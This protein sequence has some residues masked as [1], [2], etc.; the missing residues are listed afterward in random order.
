MNLS[1]SIVTALK[2]KIV[3]YKNNRNELALLAILLLGLFLRIYD[4]S[5]ESIWFDEG[6][7]VMYAEL[8]I[9]Q[10]L[11]T[12]ASKDCTPPLYY[13]ILHYWVGMFGESEFF[14]KL[15][16]VIIGLSS[17]YILYKV[18]TL[19]FNK[20]V[21]LLS[22]LI[23]AI[24]SFHIYY[25]Q[26][27]RSYGLMVLLTLLSFYFLIKILKKRKLAVSI[28]YIITSILLMYTHVYGLFIIIAQNIFLLTLFLFSHKTLEL[29]FRKWILIQCV[30]VIAYA[31]WIFFGLLKQI[32]FVQN[33]HWHAA[34]KV[35]HIINSFYTY[36]GSRSLLMVFLALSFFS[37]LS[38][39]RTEDGSFDRK[40][41]LS[42][43]ED[44]KL[45]LG[46]SNANKIYFLLVWL[47]TPIILPF[48]ISIFITP[49]YV[50]RFTITASLAF[51]LLVAKGIND[52]SR[53]Y[54]KS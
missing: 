23:L 20:N 16:S 35:M 54:V 49:I 45:V 8:N 1:S 33:Y 46:L 36:S 25:S 18:G 39:K 6:G 48:L 37:I 40:N 13:V 10:L 34:P 31:P 38:F 22:S 3:N 26:E 21:G 12:V 9:F 14:V 30:L 15:L 4:L 2:E 52:I 19:L 32:T 5:T 41:L 53:K 44:R 24:S 42:S 11:E 51:Y 43:A 29:N 50:T 7:S 28:G 17:I 27:A 47:F